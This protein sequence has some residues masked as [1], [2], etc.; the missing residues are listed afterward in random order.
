MAATTA[1]VKLD[2]ETRARLKKLGDAR[3]RSTHW[4]MQCKP[5]VGPWRFY[6]LDVVGRGNGRNF[7]DLVRC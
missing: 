2:G 7:L 1:G 5:S 3:Q 4:L 6:G